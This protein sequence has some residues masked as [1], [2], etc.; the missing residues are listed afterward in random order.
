MYD[1]TVLIENIAGYEG[2]EVT[3]KGWLYNK[4]GKGKLLF[5]KVRDGSGLIQCVAFQA[6]LS[7]EVFDI[8]KRIPQESSLIVTGVVRKDERA[9]GFPGGYEIG[10]KNLEIV[11]MA[12]DYPITPKEHGVEFLMDNRHLWVRSSRQWAILRIRATV[13]KAI[14]DWLDN[15]GY[16]LVDTPILSSN[17][18]ENSTDLFELDYFGTP[19]YLAQTGQLYNEANMMSFGK[20]YAFGPTF[21]AEKS[22]TRRHLI[23][24]W[25]VEP[26]M[27]YFSLEDLMA[28]EEEFVSYIVQTVL[29]TRKL[30][31]AL[32]ERDTTKLQNVKAPFPRIAYDDAVEMLKQLEAETTDAEQKQLLHMEWG[33]DF[34]SPHETAVAERFDRPVFVYHY[35]TAVKAFYMQPVAGRK[36]VCRSV[37]LLAPEGYGEITGG[38][39]RIYDGALLAERVKEIGINPENYRWYLDLRRY[40]S[41]PHAGFGLGVERTVAWICGLPHIRETIPYARMLHRLNP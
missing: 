24:F 2:Q 23:E 36:E 15:H 10:I 12:E 20:V 33:T 18:G 9:P 19:A 27:A 11:Q 16:T 29:E 41:V 38:S 34:G 39:E 7:E 22:K 8:A 26:E 17:A 6:D 25:M 35:P 3:L 37:D 40:G 21:R 30:E 31:L 13:I 5:L 1:V 14:R 28:M 4:T 32:I